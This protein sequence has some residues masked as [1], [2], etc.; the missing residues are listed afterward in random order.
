MISFIG[1]DMHGCPPKRMPKMWEGIDWLYE[2]T[3]S[4]YADC[5]VRKN[6]ED[7]LGIKKY[8]P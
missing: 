6:A 4:D 2:H 5:V 8:V 1:S 7:I 3:D